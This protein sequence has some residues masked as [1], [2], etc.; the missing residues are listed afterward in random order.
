MMQIA[1]ALLTIMGAIITG[2]VAYK[3]NVVKELHFKRQEEK[4]HR[5][6][7]AILHMAAYLE[8]DYAY[9]ISRPD[10]RTTEGLRS[11]LRAEY[12]QMTFYASK[13]VVLATRAFLKEPTQ[14]T[15][16]EVLLAMRKDLW[17]KRQ[18]LIMQEIELDSPSSKY[19]PEGF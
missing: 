10:I 4:E 3:F 6:K 18:D 19:K 17:V 9:M 11:N 2:Y 16:A 14:K 7:S 15:F 13:E 8:D 1:L 5:Y 12:H